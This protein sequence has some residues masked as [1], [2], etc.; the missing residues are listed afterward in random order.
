M[1]FE[2]SKFYK[3]LKP[4]KL[5]LPFGNFY[6]Y[7]KFVVAEMHEGVHFD[8]NKTEIL[9][10]ELLNY[11]GEK[12][13]IA[14]VSNRINHYSIDPQ[15]WAKWKTEFDFI[16][17]SAIIVYNNATLMNAT[18]EKSLPIEALNVVQALQRLSIGFCI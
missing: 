4:D 3:N 6:L 5:L 7:E 10:K 18:I 14:F 9:I 11:Y 1:K 12:P 13:K 17:A 8:W 2:N 15:N 16:I